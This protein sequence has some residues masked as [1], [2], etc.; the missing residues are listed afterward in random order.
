MAAEFL[1]CQIVK[2]QESRSITD[3]QRLGSWADGRFDADI[4][5]FA[6]PCDAE[7]LQ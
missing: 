2:Q 1:A 6:K 4:I 7:A 3:N 5:N